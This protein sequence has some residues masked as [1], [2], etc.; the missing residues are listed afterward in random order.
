M[1]LSSPSRLSSQIPSPSSWVSLMSSSLS[2][3]S[4][5]TTDSPGLVSLLCLVRGA[6]GASGDSLPDS[7]MSDDW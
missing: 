7:D 1:V 6:R 5:V 3:M 2:V 4:G